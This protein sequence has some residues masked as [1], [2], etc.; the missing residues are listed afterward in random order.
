MCGWHGVGVGEWCVLVMMG[1]LG[2]KEIDEAV[3]GV[4]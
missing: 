1:G 4:L 3:V 2:V